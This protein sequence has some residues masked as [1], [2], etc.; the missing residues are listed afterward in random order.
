MGVLTDARG[1]PV[2]LEV[3][4]GNTRDP[5][6]FTAQID[7]LPEEFGLC[8]V[9]VV[10]DRG[11]ITRVHREMLAEHGYA[12]I[13]ALRAPAIGQL[14]QAGLL[15]LSIFDQHTLTEIV[16]PAHPRRRLVICRNWRVARERKRK[17]KELLVATAGLLARIHKR[18]STGRLQDEKN[19]DLTV[20]KAVNRYKVAKHFVIDIGPGSF[21]FTV[22]QEAVAREAMLDGIYVV[23][24]SVDGEDMSS[25]EVVTHYNSLKHVERA[26][27]TMKSMVLEI[28]PISHCLADRVR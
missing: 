22:D 20:G 24:T 16:D 17:R 11:L 21:R 3:F 27:R 28:R 15:Q 18:V 6:A 9:A 4:S 8:Q 12:W 2:A 19:I 5:Q 26:F 23:K 10:G 7:R 14:H 25:E 13:T 1:C